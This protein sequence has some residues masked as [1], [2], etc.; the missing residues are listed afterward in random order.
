MS[1]LL[2]QNGDIVTAADRWRGDVRIRDGRIVELG[3]HLG[4]ATGETRIDA[5][6]LLVV[7]GGVDPHVHLSLPVAGTV[8]ADDFDSGSAAALVGGTTT[9]VDFVHPERGQDFLEAFEAR[10]REASVARCDH[11]FH[12]AVT[13]W[14]ERGAER[15]RRTVES[16]TTSFK[17]YL[18]YLETVGLVDDDLVDV[19]AAAAELDAV[20]LAHAEHG[21]VIERLR[22]RLAA[23]EPDHPR[24]H[25]LSRPPETEGEATARIATLASLTGARLY[26]VHVTCREARDAIAAA[27]SRGARVVGETCPQYLLLDD[28]V[29]EKPDFEGAAYVIAPPIRPAGHSEALWH[30]LES[31]TLGSVGTD[32]CP[33]TMDQKRLGR[34]DFR[35]IPGGAAGIEHRAALLF[36][37]GVVAGRFD[38]CRWV[39]LVS[40]VP[41][42]AMDLWPRKGTL[43]PGSDADLVLWDPEAT[44]TI[45][46]ATHRHRTDRSIFEGF[47]VRG[48]PVEVIAGGRR[49]VVDGDVRAEPG[50]GR[51]LARSRS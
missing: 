43:A 15:M 5:S 42:R 44:S 51:W 19:L 22:D 16:G 31:G 40:T 35:R 11:A 10:R 37:H 24:L 1:G 26:V 32:H 50:D 9:F 28:S 18:A 41:A 33:F 49:A 14:D 7:P 30:G 39:E 45:S 25:P 46:A 6:G 36:T 29:Y 8:S 12:M 27:R 4:P 13:W 21:Q 47:E 34:H 20:V 48:R 2:V 3:A 38:A 17:V 23:T